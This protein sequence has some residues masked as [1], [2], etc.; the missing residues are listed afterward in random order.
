MNFI[1]I[2]LLLR[3]ALDRLR[4]RLN[5]YLVDT[6][7]HYKQ[8]SPRCKARTADAISCTAAVIIGLCPDL[9]TVKIFMTSKFETF[10][11]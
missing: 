4:V 5:M 8:L 9:G 10:K 7:A 3:E 6:T 2:G 11:T 1:M